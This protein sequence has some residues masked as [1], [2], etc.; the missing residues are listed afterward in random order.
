M[1]HGYLRGHE[2]MLHDFEGQRCLLKKRILR[3]T[4]KEGKRRKS[5]TEAPHGALA[6]KTS[7]VV[8]EESCGCLR[9]GFVKDG[10]RRQS[11]AKAWYGRLRLSDSS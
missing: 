9:N 4:G 3:T 5:G 7:G 1:L 10:K 8:E 2:W 11:N 6:T